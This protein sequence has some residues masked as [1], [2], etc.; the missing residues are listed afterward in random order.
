MFETLRDEISLLK[1]GKL[2]IVTSEVV[3]LLADENGRIMYPCADATGPDLK[4]LNKAV[5]AYL[6]KDAAKHKSNISLQLVALDAFNE[7][8]DDCHV[9]DELEQLFSDLDENR[10]DMDESLRLQGAS[11]ERREQA[12]EAHRQWVKD[13][14]QGRENLTA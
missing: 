11:V 13:L 7:A 12:M 5:N 3:K 10:E 6:P 4:N 8:I 2:R 14:A 1:E 9:R